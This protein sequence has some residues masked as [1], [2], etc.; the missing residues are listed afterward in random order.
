[1]AWPG[2]YRLDQVMIWSGRRGVRNV[3]Y[4][5]LRGGRFAEADCC[6][7][8][9]QRPCPAHLRE[10]SFPAV[11]EYQYPAM[12]FM[13]SSENLVLPKQKNSEETEN[14]FPT[15]TFEELIY[16][17]PENTDSHEFIPFME[18]LALPGQNSEATTTYLFPQQMNVFNATQRSLKCCRCR[19]Q[20]SCFSRSRGI[21]KRQTT[22]YPSDF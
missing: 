16:Q 3:L 6:R 1:M 20:K 8:D 12:D 14:T 9:R 17:Q 5:Q 11:S 19:I 21:A 18:A 7:R 10:T 2:Q 4:P 13:S 22:R 15:F